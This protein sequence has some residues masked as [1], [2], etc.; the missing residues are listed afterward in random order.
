MSNKISA[1]KKELNLI[2]KKYKLNYLALFGSRAEGTSRRDSDFDIAY[3]SRSEIDYGQEVFLME[4]LAKALK[5]KKIDL[6][7]MG[8]AGPLLMKEVADKGILIAEF[9]PNSFDNFQIYAF[10]QYVEAK[11]LL[12]MREEYVKN[13]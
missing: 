2:A 4:R 11:P 1:D 12:K 7:N 3:S 9:T 10:M 13:S 8:Q 5:V 6:V